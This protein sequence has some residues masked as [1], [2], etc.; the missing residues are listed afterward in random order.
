MDAEAGAFAGQMAH[1]PFEDEMELALRE[2]QEAID[3]ALN[4]KEAVE[5]APRRSYIR[6]VQ[7]E[8]VEKHHLTSVSIGDEPNRRLKVLPP[9]S[10]E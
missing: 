3:T 4:E 7:H 1:T 10:R 8:L 9:K 6:R 5:L 2:A